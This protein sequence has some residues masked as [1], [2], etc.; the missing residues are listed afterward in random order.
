MTADVRDDRRVVL[1]L[2]PEVPTGQAELVVTV[3]PHDGEREKTRA[4]AVERFLALARCSLFRSGGAYPT[5][6]ELHDRH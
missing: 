2:P 1:M 4:A 6:E 5:R 3:D